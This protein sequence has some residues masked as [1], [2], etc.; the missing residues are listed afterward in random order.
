MASLDVKRS[1]YSQYTLVL[2][3][4]EEGMIISLRCIYS[5]LSS[6][7]YRKTRNR[8]G[9][10]FCL[11]WTVGLEGSMFGSFVNN[12]YL[13]SYCTL[14]CHTQ[15]LSHRIWIATTDPS[16]QPSARYWM[17]WFKIAL[18]RTSQCHC[19]HRFLVLLCSLELILNQRRQ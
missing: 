3:Q 19:H 13:D 7:F 2:T 18:Q 11:R 14:V 16:R 17:L 8:T 4:R 9:R 6:P 1:G 10:G 5:T 15:R 12:V